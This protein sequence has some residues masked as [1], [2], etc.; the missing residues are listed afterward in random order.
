MFILIEILNNLN[1]YRHRKRF[2]QAEM[3]AEEWN[4]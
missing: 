3:L 2:K 1:M 4:N